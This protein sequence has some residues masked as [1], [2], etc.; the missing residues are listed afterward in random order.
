MVRLWNYA[1]VACL[2]Y[3]P[4]NIDSPSIIET[5]NIDEKVV[6]HEN[7]YKEEEETV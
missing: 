6:I 4:R 3:V 7:R 1:Q 5:D 2:F